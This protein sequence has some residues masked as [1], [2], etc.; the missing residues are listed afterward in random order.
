MAEWTT[1]QTILDDYVVDSVLGEGGMGIVYL[2]HSRTSGRQFAVKRATGLKESDRR[3]FL[4]ELQTWIDLPEHPN[5]VPCRFFRTVGDEVVIFADYVE[6][7]SM[8][9]WIAKGKLTTLEKILDVAIQFAWGLYAIHER[10][11]IHQD[12]KP[13]NVLMTASGSPMVADFGLARTRLLATDLRVISPAL[14]SGQESVLVSCGGMTPAYASPE[15]RAGKPLSRKTDIWSWGVSVLDMFI[16]EVSCPHG[17]HIAADVLENFIANGQ[18]DQSLPEI[19]EDLAFLLLHCFDHKYENRLPDFLQIIEALKGVYERCCCREYKK[20]CCLPTFPTEVQQQP[21]FS[22]RYVKTPEEWI[23]YARQMAGREDVPLASPANSEQ[24]SIVRAIILMSESC[25]LLGKLLAGNN[26]DV[27]RQYLDAS[28]VLAD[29]HRRLSDW[30]GCLGVWKKTVERLS[31]ASQDDSERLA[32]LADALYWQ[33][34]VFADFRQPQDAC[35]SC[36]LAIGILNSLQHTPEYRISLAKTYQVRAKVLAAQGL[37]EEARTDNRGAADE[38]QEIAFQFPNDIAIQRA[39]ALNFHNW[40]VM[41]SRAGVKDIAVDLY[42]RAIATRES[43]HLQFPEDD[44]L[45]SDLAGS[46][47]NISGLLVDRGDSDAAL[48]FIGKALILREGIAKSGERR[49]FSDALAKIYFNKACLLLQLGRHEESV[50]E[51]TKMFEILL[52]LVYFEGRNDLSELLEN[53]WENND[54]A[55]EQI[56]KTKPTVVD[57]VYAKQVARLRRLSDKDFGGAFSRRLA[58]LLSSWAGVKETQGKCDEAVA[59][60]RDAIAMLEYNL[61]DQLFG[62]DRGVLGLAYFNLGASLHNMRDEAG[63]RDYWNR[64][65]IWC[66]D[67]GAL[68]KGPPLMTCFGQACNALAHQCVLNRDYARALNFLGEVENAISGWRGQNRSGLEQVLENA[69]KLR[70]KIRELENDCSLSGLGGDDCRLADLA[71]RHLKRGELPEAIDIYEQVVLSNPH[72]ADLWMHLGVAYADA[73][74]SESA[75]IALQKSVKL[76]EEQLAS[77]PQIARFHLANAY[78]TIADLLQGETKCKEACI[79]YK[80]GITIRKKCIEC[81]FRKELLPCL[82]NDYLQ[83][84]RALCGCGQKMLAQASVLEALNILDDLVNKQG[85]KEHVGRLANCQMNAACIEANLGRLALAAEH[86]EHV[87]AIYEQMVRSGDS[88]C[89]GQLKNAMK[90]REQIRRDLL[91]GSKQ[92]V[93]RK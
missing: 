25:H 82:A 2:V 30:N 32:C 26:I 17:G 66:L 68:L 37:Y 71:L 18:E 5:I 77:D 47:S 42:Q 85:L 11:L 70:Q 13:G 9:D 40:A 69:K 41:E 87:V 57:A 20:V 53:A 36:E 60:L 65:R 31:K 46:Y 24:G 81:D 38:L 63:A 34:Q 58:M 91:A 67:A 3:N 83:Q 19:P 64:S 4:A 8:A 92:S 16:G 86:L 50:E 59:L 21:C 80:K 88:G 33:G 39:L 52:R 73:G 49:E 51:Y 61:S 55:L 75:I 6:G 27:Y 56:E 35:C 12:V 74:D 28:W 29:L 84:A 14:P 76:R 10:G 1:G 89:A 45:S 93:R 62:Q 22:G 48:A 43:L 90:M 79:Q 72:N 23:T 78:V 7:G 44:V 54:T 15:Q